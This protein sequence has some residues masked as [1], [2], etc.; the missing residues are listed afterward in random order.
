MQAY[1]KCKLLE[2][3]QI[4][5]RLHDEISK[6]MF[7]NSTKECGWWESNRGSLVNSRVPNGKNA[8]FT[9]ALLD[10]KLTFFIRISPR[11]TA[12]TECNFTLD[13]IWDFLEI[14]EIFMWRAKPHVSPHSTRMKCKKIEG[15]KKFLYY[16]IYNLKGKSI[17]LVYNLLIMSIKR[18]I[19]MAFLTF[20][21]VGTLYKQY[22]QL[23]IYDIHILYVI[24]YI[25][26]VYN[27]ILI[28]M[29]IEMLLLL[30]NTSSNSITLYIVIGIIC[31]A[32]WYS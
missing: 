25:Y 19:G 12:L 1:F 3:P 9:S 24:V 2:W 26:I 6:R 8:L 16:F 7:R 32:V 15:R 18:S 5:K 20:D 13:K 11:C 14:F 31:I 30:R 23:Y 22:I 10:Q 21:R 27:V 4:G 17:L 28:V 29:Y